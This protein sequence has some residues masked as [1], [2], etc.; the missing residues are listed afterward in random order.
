MDS[1]K[2]NHLTNFFKYLTKNKYIFIPLVF[3]F[4]YFF[5]YRSC[6]F[7]FFKT[8][9]H[10]FYFFDHTVW[11]FVH[12]KGLFVHAFNMSFWTDH[13]YP[14]LLLFVP[15]Y[16]IVA[17]PFWMFII[18]ALLAAL[19]AYPILS[20]AYEKLGKDKVFVVFA[21]LFFYLPFRLYGNDF[22]GELW[23]AA[24]LSWI[25]YLIEK[26]KDGLLVAL[27]FL[28]PFFKEN[29]VTYLS[30]VAVYL[31]LIKRRWKLGLFTFFW[32]LLSSAYLLAWFIPSFAKKSSSLYMNTINY[33]SNYSYLGEGLLDKINTI[34]SHPFV[35][36]GKFFSI[37][38]LAYF[39]A[40]FAPLGFLSLFSPISIFALG[41]F[42]QNTLSSN[43]NFVDITAHYSIIFTP[44]VFIS[45][46]FA[47]EKIVNY[48]SVW[49][50]VAK[51]FMIFFVIINLLYIIIFEIRT[52][53]P[54]KD[55][56]VY[57][58]MLKL[59]PPD[60]SVAADT[61]MQ[62]HLQY[63]ARLFRVGMEPASTEFIVLRKHPYISEKDLP[64]LFKEQP[65]KAIAS[66]LLGNVRRE[67][68]ITNND[69][70]IKKYINDATYQTKSSSN[71]WVLQKLK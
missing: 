10:D 36:L 6:S 29:A 43:L 26:Q 53:I 59:I 24:A 35:L 60:A 69:L 30:F 32:G 8:S 70:L 66:L 57:Y 1:Q 45:G 64:R 13:F 56:Q 40:I 19:M 12:G 67:S 47:Y 46:I 5:I 63:R 68:D 39:L 54:P 25:I 55:I 33:S 71:I 18:Q 31:T 65:K 58:Q 7:L 62:G 9:F 37:N 44:I 42:L 41:V 34:F 21:L 61:N 51:F 16:A 22:H 15:F 14:W 11:S 27:I 4:F 38:N 49:L 23:Q 3:L 52:F 28:F 2:R 48:K 20:L 50:K 17:S